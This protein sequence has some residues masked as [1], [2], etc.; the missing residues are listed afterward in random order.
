MR[1][2]LRKFSLTLA[3]A[4]MLAISLAACSRP[5]VQSTQAN[6]SFAE[7]AIDAPSAA[8]TALD[9]EIDRKIASMTLE[10]KVAQ[11]F[12]VQPGTLDEIGE[13][14]VDAIGQYPVGGFLFMGGN[15]E[16]P[17]QIQS[18]LS[19]AKQRSRDAID[20][21]IFLCVDE[22]GGSV[23]RIAD[24][25]D[26]GIADVGDM[27]AIGAT[28]DANVARD[29]ARYIGSYLADLGFNVDFAPVADLAS[30]NDSMAARSFGTDVNLTSSM[31]R[32]QVEGFTQTGML[33]AVKHFPGIGGIEE[34][35]H[36]ASIFNHQTIDEIRAT[37]LK[38]FAASIE[39]GAPFV[40]VGHLSTPEAAGNDTPAS[41]SKTWL[42][43]IL[44]DEMGFEGIIITDSLG[45]AA[46]YERYSQHDLGALAL[47]AGADMLLKPDDFLG[48]YQ[49]VLEAIA[50]GDLTEK[51]IDESVERVLR[52]KYSL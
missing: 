7:E 41:V 23:T 16:D 5:A 6:D 49:G 24:D 42:T 30:G 31:V 2:V 33:C 38:P 1:I 14:G 15:V 9:Q 8:Q 48:M 19:A 45:M 43:D 12:I 52:A 17:N 20:L 27:Q 10:Q 28:G 46:V 40:M 4:L 21:P 22:E 29:A 47:Q 39:A 25:P 35:S 26:F 3:V 34:D 44:R 37:S 51:R 11:L 36:T 32:A 13:E 50:R 18:A